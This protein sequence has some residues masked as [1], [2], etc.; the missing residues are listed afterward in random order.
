MEELLL[1]KIKNGYQNLDRI[2]LNNY[3]DN[4]IDKTILKKLYY[5]G[6]K[7]M[8]EKKNVEEIDKEL[9]KE[10]YE[11]IEINEKY[12]KKLSILEKPTIYF[13]QGLQGSGKTTIGKLLGNYLDQDE[14]N[15]STK[16]CQGYLYQYSNYIK[17]DLYLG[18]CNINKKHYQKYLEICW[19]NNCKV[20]FLTQ[21]RKPL[22]M[23]ICLSNIFKRSNSYKN[24]IVGNSILDPL[25]TIGILRDNYRNYQEMEYGLKY[26]IYNNNKELEEEFKKIYKDNNLFLEF[27]I[28][29][30]DRLQKLLKPLDN[31][32]LEINY[33]KEDK[34]LIN[35]IL[36]EKKNMVYTGVFVNH[37]EI[38]DLIPE[39]IK[40]KLKTLKGKI[41]GDHVTQNYIGKKPT[42]K[43]PI[44]TLEKEYK[45]IIYDLVINQDNFMAFQVKI[46]DNDNEISVFSN[47]PHLT[48]F[49]PN[50]FKPLQASKFINDN[51]N[52]QRIPINKEIIGI[53]KAIF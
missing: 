39:E 33:L 15:G 21:K 41:S 47:Q 32:L 12:E 4:S 44:L 50:G 42:V 7:L 17:E 36:P 18:R 29:N 24:L 10:Y 40:I 37:Q 14:F 53:S 13:I 5:V 9:I 2:Y 30:H 19:R 23:A 3:I 1:D 26:Q 16:S 25:M 27:V 6:I 45:I 48:L 46:F 43:F 51:I 34:R 22:W 28:K 11:K 8:L 31:L 20:I 49:T 35:Y 38:L 52:V